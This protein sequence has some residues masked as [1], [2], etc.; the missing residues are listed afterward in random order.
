[1]TTNLAATNRHPFVS[2][3]IPVF[4]DSARLKLCLEALEGQSY[5]ADY[6]VVVVD[7]GSTENIEEV[8]RP[9][10]HVIYA[11]ESK[12][13]SYAARNKGI[14]VAKA[15]IFAFT[16]GDCLPRQDWLEKGVGRLM[17]L[18]GCGLVGGKVEIFAKDAKNPTAV[19][20]YEIAF[21]FNQKRKVEK[22]NYSVTANLFTFRSI[23]T[24]VGLFNDNMKSLGDREWCNRA[25]AAG[26]PL[27]YADDVVIDHP[28]RS[29]FSEMI[30]RE[31]RLTGGTMRRMIKKNPSFLY[32][33]RTVAQ[34]FY[35][36][37]KGIVKLAANKDHKLSTWQKFKVAY[38]IASRRLF[39]IFGLVRLRLGG[40]E[41]R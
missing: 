31:L 39:H 11:H 18:S 5:P 29:S 13:G 10:K 2:V 15:E 19:E 38:V 37:L 6:E 34:N 30:S 22:L 36:L 8:C 28:A 35:Y 26:Y 25:V 1:M 20:L 27:V 12:P 3:I 4:N 16:D 24:K 17:S 7:N 14:A 33:L 32:F 41:R 40:E 23:F 9:F 21:E